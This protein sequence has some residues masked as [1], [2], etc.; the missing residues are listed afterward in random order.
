MTIRLAGA[1]VNQTPIDW[2]G[3]RERILDAIRQAK[4]AGV[5][6]LCFP[7]L[8]I[9]GYGC[10]DLFL[11]DWIYARALE[12]LLKIVPHCSDI[13]VAIGVPL[14]VNGHNRNTSCIIENGRIS[15]FYAK[16]FMALDGVHYE[17]RWFI[18]WPAGKVEKVEI[19][20]E[21]FEVGDIIIDYKSAR[22]GF[23]ICED[24]WRKEVRPAY[25]C[26]PRN[27]NLIMNPSASH[28]ALD[29]TLL[30]EDLVV[31]SS[32]K[33]SCTYVFANLLG[34]EA[35]RMIYDG[36]ILIA[37]DG[38]LI[39]RNEWLSF[40]DV[41]LQWA[42]VDFENPLQQYDPPTRYARDRNT[43]F[44]KA[45]TLGLFDYLR[46]SKSKGFILSL[47]GGADSSTTAILVSEM[48][49]RSIASLGLK[50][51]F[52][53]SGL[54]EV[55]AKGED[56]IEK[57][58]LAHLLTTAYQATVNSSEDT[59][60]SARHLAEELGATYYRWNIDEEV[61]SY[62]SKIEKA[63][64]RPLTWEQDDITLQNIQARARSPIIWMLANINNALLLTTSNRS[65]GDVGYTTM[66]GDTSGSIAPI[67]GVSKPFIIQWLK[68][69]ESALGY[70]SLSYVNGLQPSAELRPLENTQTDEEDLMPFV[71]LLEIEILAIRERK[72][73]TEVYGFLKG[74]KLTTDELLKTYITRFFR[75][76]SRN[77]WKRERI[78]P[79]FHL[80][81][82]NVDPRSWCRFPILSAG[83]S[84]EL[85]QLE[86]LH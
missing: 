69:A 31:N 42:D 40:E 59:E 2:T 39:K 38:V 35:G 79:S 23:E 61:G 51:F 67:A 55:W 26:V 47:S 14:Q 46:K 65:E 57:N 15:G 54:P 62:T 9:T 36:E 34:N 18:P 83:F 24:A 21:E 63:I 13:L 45:A 27:V 48:V 49:K 75:L 50:R 80:D 41:N 71:I 76:W 53:R 73:P 86:N 22:I 56:S 70:S 43:E 8:C 81:D 10:E 68:W 33:F 4:E 58:I 17:P 78:A 77:Q 6:I 11:G 29:K 7:E 82:F 72:S 44:I 28:F 84:E 5:E 37:R 16:Q 25:R 64:G 19:D 3:N 1:T 66:D 74:E 52:L 60:E 12:E 30:R 20:G 85:K 32:R